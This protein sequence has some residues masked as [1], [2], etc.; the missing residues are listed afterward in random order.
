MSNLSI[1]YAGGVINTGGNNGLFL[2]V[3]SG[4]GAVFAFSLPQFCL[5]ECRESPVFSFTGQQGERTLKNGGLERQLLYQSPEGL[6]LEAELQT[7]PGSPVIRF[8]FRLSAEG[9]FHFSKPDGRDDVLYTEFSVNRADI[10]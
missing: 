7:F 6:H 8:R 2:N 10:T 3:T 4:S 5:R 1:D 9:N